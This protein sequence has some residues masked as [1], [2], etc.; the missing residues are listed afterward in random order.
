M[1]HYPRQLELNLVYHTWDNRS[2]SV[3]MKVDRVEP[4]D[5]FWGRLQTRI[6]EEL[7]AVGEY[8]AWKHVRN[9]GSRGSN[10]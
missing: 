7:E 5:D 8:L 4:M 2:P 9:P 3:D 6:G 1:K 10:P